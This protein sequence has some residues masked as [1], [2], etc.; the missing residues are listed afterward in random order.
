MHCPNCGQQQLSAEVKFCSRC[1]FPMTGVA[2][3][4]SNGG[5]LSRF[6]PNNFG[7]NSGVPDKAS[8]RKKGLKMGGIMLISGTIIVPLLGVLEAPDKLIGTMALIFFLGGIL[9]IIYA[10]IFQSKFPQE[11][12]FGKFVT[13]NAGKILPGKSKQNEL[14]PNSVNEADFITNS[15]GQWRD[16][17]DL[18]PI[19]VT[20]NTTKL[21]QRDDEK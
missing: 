17:N 6:L 21:L 13:D 16:T 8:P 4:L 19:S 14:P 11:S 15:P 20:E 5:D 3:L 9:R 1:G 18:S 2:M 12:S 10:L 7:D